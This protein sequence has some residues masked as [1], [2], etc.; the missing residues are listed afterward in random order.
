MNRASPAGCVV[1]FFSLFLLGLAALGFYGVHKASLFEDKEKGARVMSELIS[2][3]GICALTG[4][5]LMVV[6]WRM[7]KNADLSDMGNP[8]KPKIR[9]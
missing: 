8:D 4:L 7:V 3:A 9:F 6:A 2:I 1:G 5:V